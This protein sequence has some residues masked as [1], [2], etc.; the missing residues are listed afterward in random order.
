MKPANTEVRCRTSENDKERQRDDRNDRNRHERSGHRDS[1]PS[2]GR[3][4]PDNG[5]QLD[6]GDETQLSLRSLL[7]PEGLSA[8]FVSFGG[9]VA[10]VQGLDRDLKVVEGGFARI[11]EI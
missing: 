5:D 8:L 9:N 2:G 6:D 10:V 7:S 11:Q 3:Q 4:H 1:D